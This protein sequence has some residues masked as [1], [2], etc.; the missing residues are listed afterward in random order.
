MRTVN[1][2]SSL[3]LVA[4]L[5]TGCSHRNT[6]PP[7]QA[8]APPLQTG[9][10]TLNQPKTTQPQE[11][12]ETPLASPLPPP[13]A[14]S[15]PLPPPPPPKKVRKKQVKQAPAKPADT[16]QT[17]AATTGG[18]TSPPAAPGSQVTAQAAPPQQPPATNGT[19]SPIGQLTTGDSAM[20][21][22][23]KHETE[24]LINDTLQGVNA[25][26]RALSPE[27]QVTAAQ[28]HAFLKQAQLA[29]DNGDTDGGRGLATKAKQL[30]DE[31]TKP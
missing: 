1:L 2:F 4:I 10:G 8:Q 15:V 6:S 11:K 5:C 7:V 9:P 12:S 31:L 29:L 24:D 22:K 18:T 25:I 26:K 30:L 28:I 3:A 16:A 19:A 13:S 20:G 17:P 23:A 14:Q 27:E 21:E